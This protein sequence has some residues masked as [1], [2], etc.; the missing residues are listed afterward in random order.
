MREERDASSYVLLCELA[1]P[2]Q[3]DNAGGAMPSVTMGDSDAPVHPLQSGE[4]R[5]LGTA[6]QVA[7]K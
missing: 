2:H 5:W 4:T 7:R 6:A 3:R 1:A